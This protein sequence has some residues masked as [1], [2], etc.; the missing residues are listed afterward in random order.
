MIIL[1][2]FKITEDLFLWFVRPK[3]QP[4]VLKR[5]VL[6]S[7]ALCPVIHFPN[8]VVGEVSGKVSRLFLWIV[9]KRLCEKL[10][11]LVTSEVKN[12]IELSFK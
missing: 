1:Y 3:V 8:D 4:S 6:Q 2:W 11:F 9:L 7:P 5:L 10:Y 12:Q